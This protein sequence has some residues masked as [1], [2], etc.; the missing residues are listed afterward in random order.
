MKFH[1]KETL[2]EIE[3]KTDGNTYYLP[4]ALFERKNYGTVRLETRLAYVA[5]LD[6]LLKKPGF[7]K[8]MTAVI[9][10][11]NPEIAHTL[12]ILANKPVD[13]EK[14]SKYLEELCDAELIEINKQDIYVVNVG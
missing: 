13:Q 10:A 7:T 4:K 1:T 6:T 2:K 9:K 8:E 3:N 11:D 12:A 5:L 14:I